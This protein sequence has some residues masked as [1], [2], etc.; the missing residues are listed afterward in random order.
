VQSACNFLIEGYA[1]IFT[2]FTNEISRPFHVRRKPLYKNEWIIVGTNY[3]PTTC[4]ICGIKTEHA[5]LRDMK[6]Y[7]EPVESTGSNCHKR[8]EDSEC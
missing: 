3:L 6:T 7:E 1:E 8:N 5:R 4:D 2:L